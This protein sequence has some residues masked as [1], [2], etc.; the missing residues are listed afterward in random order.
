MCVLLC[1]WRRLRE[2][3]KERGSR[4][5]SGSW[6]ESGKIEEESDTFQGGKRKSREEEREKDSSVPSWRTREFR[7]VVSCRQLPPFTPLISTVTWHTAF[8]TQRQGHTHARTHIHTLIWPWR[9][10]G[11]GAA[12]CLIDNLSPL[13]QLHNINSV[14][15]LCPSGS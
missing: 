6:R 13:H 1:V 3:M 10:S 8:S 9:K 11:T 14:C 15:W 12:R 7:A 5:S 2:W 4:G